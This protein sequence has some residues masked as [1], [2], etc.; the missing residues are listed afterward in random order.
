MLHHNQIKQSQRM[1]Q[2]LHRLEADQPRQIRQYWQ[3]GVQQTYIRP[4]EMIEDEFA[5]GRK[6]FE[7]W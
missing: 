3:A 2:K 6:G 1:Q 4:F 7:V 5:H